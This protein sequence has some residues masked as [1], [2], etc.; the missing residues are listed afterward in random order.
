MRWEKNKV[1]TDNI[2]NGCK[3][4]WSATWEARSFTPCNFNVWKLGTESALNE[5]K[6]K[7]TQCWSSDWWLVTPVPIITPKWFLYVLLCFK[8][9]PV[10]QHSYSYWRCD[11]QKTGF[12][13]LTDSV[14]RRL[15]AEFGLQGY[16][17]RKSSSSD[18]AVINRSC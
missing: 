15:Y 10:L 11:W 13:S 3:D 14:N 6:W 4:W 8:Q 9:Q 1:I 12:L 17:A 16:S 2:S 5:V 7:V 18:L